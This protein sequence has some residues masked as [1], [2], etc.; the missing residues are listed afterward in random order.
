MATLTRE[1]LRSELDLFAREALQKALV[2]LG[3]RLP[4][5][6]HTSCREPPLPG[7]DGAGRTTKIWERLK[8]VANNDKSART[9]A[10]T[11]P[12]RRTVVND[13]GG[14]AILQRGFGRYQA[15]EE[16]PDS[17]FMRDRRKTVRQSTWGTQRTTVKVN[18][19][20]RHSVAAFANVD[21]LLE[22]DAEEPSNHSMEPLSREGTNVSK[23]SS[24]D[25]AAAKLARARALASQRLRSS[26]QSQAIPEEQ[27]AG[28]AAEVAETD[29]HR[30]TEEEILEQESTSLL[31]FELAEGEKGNGNQV[32]V[33]D[34]HCMSKCR[35]SLVQ[36]VD[37]NA[38][39]YTSCVLVL[40]NSVVIG[41]EADFGARHLGERSPGIFKKAS[42][43]FC[44]FFTIEI[45]LRLA[46]FGYRLFAGPDWHWNLFD[47]LVVVMQLVDEAVHSPFVNPFFEDG[48]SGSP[49]LSMSFFRLLRV[50]RL[51]RIARLV[52][53][54][55]FV[56]ELHT[57]AASIIGSL[58]SLFWTLALLLL[59][60]YILGIVVTE[61]VAEH[62]ARSELVHR[63]TLDELG[64]YYGNLFRTVLSL[65]ESITGGQSWDCMLNPLIQE[66][67]PF[68]AP[69]FC[70]YISICVFALMNSVTGVF[71]ERAMQ[72]VKADEEDFLANHM[73]EAFQSKTPSSDSISF[74]EFDELLE[75]DEMKDYFK[76]I[77]VDLSHANDIFQL[78]DVDK[79]GKIDFDEFIGQCLRLKGPAKSMDLILL[80]DETSRF[81]QKASAHMEAVES[82]LRLICSALAAQAPKCPSAGGTK[83][84][85]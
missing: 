63:E 44:L 58:K 56:E 25:G 54:L 16:N 29:R 43:G 78:L 27:T 77:N 34:H 30:A 76:A 5:A 51:V 75:T 32:A 21:P 10:M 82:Q 17:H 9:T 49:S 48:S 18:R 40:L 55:R 38:F 85:T 19:N 7:G 79:V 2:E 1:V 69:M 73:R 53:V 72:N 81:I 22:N 62:R 24:E 46:A 41:A 26:L 36:F 64:Y 20:A 14:A 50:L 74:K 15:S 83:G 28:A 61:V 47:V 3:E 71:C 70:T 35:D 13:K 57:I 11:T 45:L 39:N 67:S 84:A 66:V 33:G 4:N 80:M 52:R 6:R 42:L 8:G 23:E 59:L 60:M 37:T 31:E 68:V 12:P 65:F